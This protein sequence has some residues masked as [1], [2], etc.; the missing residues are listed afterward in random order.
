[1][2][3]SE[4]CGLICARHLKLKYYLPH[5]PNWRTRFCFVLHRMLLSPARSARQ[6]VLS[7]VQAARTFIGSKKIDLTFSGVQGS[8]PGM[9]AEFSTQLFIQWPTPWRS[10]ICIIMFIITEPRRQNCSS[11]LIQSRLRGIWGCWH[12]QTKERERER[13][14]EIDWLIAQKPTHISAVATVVLITKTFTEKYYG[15][16]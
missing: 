8:A 9:M 4:A 14:T 3:V 10:L 2:Y 12:T 6:A 5:C 15:R 16:L 1:M 13:E 11:Q 7:A